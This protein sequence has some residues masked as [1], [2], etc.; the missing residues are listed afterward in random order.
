MTGAWSWFSATGLHTQ[1][2]PG[3]REPP[4]SADRQNHHCFSEEPAQN[5]QDT[6][7]EELPTNEVF[8]FPSAPRADSVP[9]SYIHKYCQER[10]GKPGVPTQLRA[11]VRLPLLFKFPVQ[12]RPTQNHQDTGNKE[13]LEIGSF[14]AVA[15]Y[16]IN[17]N[18][19]PFSTQRIN[20]LRKK[21]GKQHPSQQSQIIKQLGV[22]LTKEV[23]DLYEKNVR[24][25]KIEI[26]EDLRRC[27]GLP[28]SWIGRINIVKMAILPNTIYRFNAISI[29]IPTQ[30]F[31]ELERAIL[32]FHLE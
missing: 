9:Q 19:W 13:Q 4:R 17:S 26:K 1:V 11:Q 24:P 27:K 28:C 5:P 21:L 3:E 14:S 23:K 16:K 31:I 29:K 2:A 32:K 10:A 6:G 20:R 30:F 18:Q 25:L 22:T 15:G 7:T 8:Q 12:E